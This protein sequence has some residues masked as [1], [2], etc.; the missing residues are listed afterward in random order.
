MASYP[1][2]QDVQIAE[3]C[4]KNGSWKVITENN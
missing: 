1:I 4:Y 2:K 3:L